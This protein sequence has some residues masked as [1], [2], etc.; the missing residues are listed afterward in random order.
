[1]PVLSDVVTFLSSTVVLS[2]TANFWVVPLLHSV[3]YMLGVFCFRW[4]ERVIMDG[5]ANILGFEKR[6]CGLF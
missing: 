4:Y 5:E 3:S 2:P 1:V 6:G